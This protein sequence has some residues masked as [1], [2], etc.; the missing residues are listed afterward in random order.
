[1]LPRPLILPALLTASVAV[2]Y[3][4]TNGPEW[5]A[6]W[7]PSGSS[8]AAAASAGAT[9]SLTLGDEGAPNTTVRGPGALLFPSS[10]PLEGLQTYS[11]AE[12]LRMDVSKEWVYQRWARKSTVTAELD[13]YGVRVPLVTGT[14]LT[15]LAGALT[16][17]FGHDGRV[18][19]LSFRGRTADTSQLVHQVVPRYGLARQ[20]AGPGEQLFELR[21]GD[22]VI[23]QL[24]TRPASVL[25][26][27]AP[28][29]SF[30]VELDL[31]RP[32]TGRP[33]LPPT[34]PAPPVAQNAPPPKTAEKASKNA[35]SEGQAA[36]EVDKERWK[37]FFPR[38]RVPKQQV[39]GLDSR[40]RLW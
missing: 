36:Q 15:D 29:E 12:V 22:D 16:Y 3:V 2:P 34:A 25:W 30:D 13:L 24:R 5:P 35:D 19:K 14:Q 1:M 18:H 38:S 40:R 17:Y 10:T 6:G 4:A 27:S 31:Q 8:A 33:I 39:P 23:S 9:S 32:E 20:A 21:R 28:H 26:D 7:K 37:L 11:I